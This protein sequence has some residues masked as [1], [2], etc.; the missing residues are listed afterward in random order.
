MDIIGI[1]PARFAS[2][3]FPGK[4]LADIDGTSMIQR[5]YDQ[6]SKAQTLKKVI[7][8]TD[9]QE[10]YQH[11]RD[12]GGEVY[13]TDKDH[14]SGTDRCHEA[15]LHQPH[16]Y[17]F[18]VNIQGDEPFI[19]PRQIED[20]TSQL[21][22]GI[23]L[24]TLAKKISNVQQL[25]DTNL[26]KVIINQAGKAAYFSRI[27]LPF[28]RNHPQHEW[29]NH[30]QFYSHVGIYAYRQDVLKEITGLEVS[31]WERSEGLEQLRW[32]YYGYAISVFQTEYDSMGIDTPEDLKKALQ[33]HKT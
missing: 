24:A 3:R 10:I 1:I 25:T 11:V 22:E 16:H 18:V 28:V 19:Q 4:A 23:Q 5:V 7:V 12:F 6:A 20:L 31:P 21:H 30:Q 9:H 15:L 8:A 33:L 29:L 32:L 13:M 2:N 17:D 26:V 27:P 14:P